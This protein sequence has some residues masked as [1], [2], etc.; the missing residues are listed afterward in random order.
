MMDKIFL[1]AMLLCLIRLDSVLA[2]DCA[3][4]GKRVANQQGG[5]LTR[6]MP[7]V[8]NGKNMCVVVIVVPAHNGQKSRR[9]EVIVPAD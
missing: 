5:M 8:Q 2:A 3:G 7:I 6:S 1:F 4:V 9:V